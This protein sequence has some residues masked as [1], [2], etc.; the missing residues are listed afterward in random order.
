[1]YMY[2]CYYGVDKALLKVTT[3]KWPYVYIVPNDEK[4]IGI[5]KPILCDLPQKL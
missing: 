1:M 3:S 5:L 2:T 4:N